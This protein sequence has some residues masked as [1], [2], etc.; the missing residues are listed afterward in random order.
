MG[1]G[2]TLMC[3]TL[4]LA[5]LHQPCLPAPEQYD[6]TKVITNVRL[7]DYPFEADRT[8]RRIVGQDEPYNYARPSLQELCIDAL[9]STDASISHFPR[10]PETVKPFLDRHGLYFSY[11]L[12]D[13]SCRRRVKQ[14]PLDRPPDIKKVY[15]ANTTLIV[16]PKMLVDQWVHEVEKHV[17]KGALRMIVV[18]KE[19]PDVKELMKYDVSCPLA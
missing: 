7:R 4:I 16:V 11:T 13:D 18:R 8:L 19:M 10:L 1:V 12:Q 6:T 5:T 14:L 15:L 9:I 2:K 17:E 3:L